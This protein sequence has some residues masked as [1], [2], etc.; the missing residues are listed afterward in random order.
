MTEVQ[1]ISL[2]PLRNGIGRYVA[3]RSRGDYAAA[4]VALDQMGYED[5]K[6][7]EVKDYDELKLLIAFEWSTEINDDMRDSMNDSDLAEDGA[8]GIALTLIDALTKYTVVERAIEGSGV[9]FLLGDKETFEA[10][11]RKD[12]GIPTARLEVSGMLKA[13]PRSRFRTRINDKVKQSKESD[14]DGTPAYVIV[15]EFGTPMVNCTR[16]MPSDG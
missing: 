3:D 5:N 14:S 13:N 4:I 12:F 15:V 8:V 2:E 7:C 6:V 1:S 10:A 16:R 9:D 11:N